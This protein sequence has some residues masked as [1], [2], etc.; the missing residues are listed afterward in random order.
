M[1]GN[2]MDHNMGHCQSLLKASGRAEIMYINGYF[3]E[4]EIL[5]E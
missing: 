2:G 1:N 5:R 3:L 4:F